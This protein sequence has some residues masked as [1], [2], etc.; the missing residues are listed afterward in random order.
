MKKLQNSLLIALLLCASLTFGQ[1]NRVAIGFETGSSLVLLYQNN[2]FDDLAWGFSSGL[3]FQYNSTNHTSIGT[4]IS[5]ERKVFTV[6]ATLTDISGKELG[7]MTFHPTY[8]YLT[9][10]L[11]VRQTL[12]KKNNYFVNAGP[13]LGYLI[14]QTNV[15]LP[16]P[17]TNKRF[18]LG[19]ITGFG[20]LFPV[21]KNLFLSLELRNNLELVGSDYIP[22]VNGHTPKT[23]ATFLL[24]GIG[25]G[26][27]PGT[28]E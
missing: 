2:V 3:A 19:L 6:H 9:I 14:N 4:G 10:P 12:G 5:L 16:Q 27:L 25:Y 20:M 15:S 28:D 1:T 8:D 22:E 7:E 26:F 11:L 17:E 24:F 23:N 18:D 21:D 13:Y